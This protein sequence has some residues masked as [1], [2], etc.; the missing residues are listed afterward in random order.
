MNRLRSS[1]NS[2]TMSQP[3]NIEANRGII[4]RL[5]HSTPDATHVWMRREDGVLVDIP[6]KNIEFTLNQFPLWRVE[7]IASAHAASG[8][9]FPQPDA[10]SLPE[11]DIEVP[12]KPSEWEVAGQVFGIQDKK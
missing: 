8:R 6:L 10:P 2:N 1:L 4:A 7:S 5:F 12:P 9:T 3:S 11:K